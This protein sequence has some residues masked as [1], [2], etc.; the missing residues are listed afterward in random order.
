MVCVTTTQTTKLIPIRTIPP[1]GVATCRAPLTGIR[2]RHGPENNTVVLTSPFDPV[3][4]VTINPSTERSPHVFGQATFD[5]GILVHVLETLN[6]EKSQVS[7]RSE[8]LS[9][10]LIH[11]LLQRAPQGLL[12]LT[13]PLA[14]LDGLQDWPDVVPK[15]PSG[16]RRREHLHPR[17]QAQIQPLGLLRPCLDLESKLDIPFGDDVGF[18]SF[19]SGKETV[20]VTM[21]LDREVEPD[22]LSD[23]CEDQPSVESFCTAGRLEASDSTAH[24]HSLAPMSGLNGLFS[25][26]FLGGHAHVDGLAGRDLAQPRRHPRLIFGEIYNGFEELGLVGWDSNFP[27]VGDEEVDDLAVLGENFAELGSLVLCGELE[28]AFG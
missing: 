3:Q 11:A 6:H 15:K 7:V 21:E 14:T 26:P 24:V 16:A 17:V 27:E 10:D 1:L 2:R 12:S 4:P 28:G 25:P 23:A 18:L 13:P 22:L 5:L 8:D 19:A 20:E 9:H